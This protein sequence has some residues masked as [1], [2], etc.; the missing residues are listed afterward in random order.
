M[1]LLITLLTGRRPH[2]LERTLASL[3]EHHADIVESASVR[4][5]HN[6]G[7]PETRVVL[8]RYAWLFEEWVT[9][10]DLLTIGQGVS[11]LVTPDFDHEY[12]MH[13]EDDWEASPGQWFGLAADLL[14][15]GC[16]QVRLRKADE[17]VL[18]KHMVTGKAIRWRTEF[19]IHTAVDAHYTFNPSLMR[20]ADIKIGFPAKDE[21]HAQAKFHAAGYR[22]VAQLVPGIFT[23][24][25]EQSLRK[26]ARRG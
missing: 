25:G 15:E 3:V 22:K 13:L 10:P 7:D 26:Q 5:L 9:T 24:I 21:R 8:N 19:G 18:P 23:H 11:M 4:V 16:F 2:Y 6:G 17:K 1:T 12:V 14:D 20:L